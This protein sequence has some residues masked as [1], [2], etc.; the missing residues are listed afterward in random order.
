MFERFTDRSRRVLA[1]AQEE[2][3]LLQHS[4][5]GCEHIL[6]GL[7]GEAHGVA[8]RVLASA[9]IELAPAR[10]TLERMLGHGA[11]PDPN[12]QPF[13]AAAKQA[14][15]R[16]LR[17]ALARNSPVIH[18]EHLLLGVVT[19]EEERVASVL[20]AF[21]SSGEQIRQRVENVLTGQNPARDETIRPFFE[22]LSARDW[23][24]LSEVLAPDVV[25][26]GP[27]G[28]E[29][30][31]REPYLDL[32]ARSVPEGYGNDV[33]RITYAAGGRSGFARV[34][35]HL[36]YPDR[37]FHLEEAYAFELDPAGLICRVE[38]FW[39]TPHLEADAVPRA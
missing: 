24:A 2:A 23:R 14:L 15:G 6:L 17:E 9:G 29:V 39:Q 18:T 38:V 11:K 36:A 21:G 32:L 13:N 33:H 3:R 27:F 31:G 26:V 12:G 16:S 19:P 34:T 35:E 28:D 5:I 37:E 8:A 20:A 10:E 22:R 1:L 30:T 4:S 7:I 25:R